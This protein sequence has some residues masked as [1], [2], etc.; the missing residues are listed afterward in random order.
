MA[1]GRHALLLTALTIFCTLAALEAAPV[2]SLLHALPFFDVVLNEQRDTLAQ[3]F[4][5]LANRA[6]VIKMTRLLRF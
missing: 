3:R 1:R 2:S 5:T 4:P 6:F